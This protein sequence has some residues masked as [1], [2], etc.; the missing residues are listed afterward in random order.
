MSE[1]KSRRSFSKKFKRELVEEFVSGRSSAEAIA[2]REGI[3]AQFIYRW[4][5]QVEQWDKNQRIETLEAD[6]MSSEDARRFR[7][8]E[9]E[10]EAYKAKVAEQMLH[11][12]LLKK[13]QPNY[14]SEKRSTGYAE[15]KRKLDRS[16]GRAK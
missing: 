13:L 4:K 2:S 7:D 1:K 10:L 15:T 16:K 11:I 5:T 6:G 8:M 3:T 9:E 12:D 14:L